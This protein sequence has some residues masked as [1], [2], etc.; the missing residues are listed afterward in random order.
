MGVLHMVMI[1]EGRKQFVIEM[2][3]SIRDGGHHLHVNKIY[4]GYNANTNIMVA[5]AM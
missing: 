2:F 3:H 1:V 4:H 5:N